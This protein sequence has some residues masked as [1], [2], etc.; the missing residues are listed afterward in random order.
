[1]AKSET[2]HIRVN[3]NVK[4]NAEK[5]LELLG[6]S[7][8]EAVNMFLHQINL[9]GGLPFDVKIPPAPN[10]VSPHSMEELFAMLETGRKQIQAGKVN[11]ASIVMARIRDEYG[12]SD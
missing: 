2:L 4:Q 5:T 8:S 7:I 11:D 3:E 6:L 10:S 1:M 9:V 12:F